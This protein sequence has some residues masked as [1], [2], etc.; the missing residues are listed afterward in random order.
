MAP[1]RIAFVAAEV[2]PFAK[3]GGLA[4]VAGALPAYL[5][6]EHDVRVFMPLHGKIDAAKYPTVAV[7]FLQ[8][9][10]IH[11]GTHFFRFSV[12]TAKLPGTEVDVYFIDCPALFD[13]PGIY[14][15]EWDEH[16]R[17]AL[18]SRAVL[19][20]CQH[21][22]WGPDI[23][24]CNDWHTALIPLYL[25]TLFSWDH[26]FARTRT[27]LTL[28]NVAYQGIFPAEV[29]GN[30]GFSEWRWLLYQDDLDRGIINF[31]KTGLL[32]AGAIT[33]VSI[34][35]A[36]EI[37]TDAFGM[38]M[39][40]VL[41]A[42]S[43]SVVGIV[44]GVDYSVWDPATDPYLK[45]PYTSA[46]VREGKQANR[47][48]LMREIGLGDDP[49]APLLAVVS[50]LTAQKGFDL[51]FEP[52]AEALRYLNLRFLVLGSGE[53][54]LEA[55]FFDLQRTF[56]HKCWFFRGY[57]ERL[58]HAIEA[59][60]DI[61]LMPSRFEP[62]GLNQMYSLKYGAVPVVR[63]T[64]GLADTVEL[65]DPQKGT[66]TGV[67]FDNYDVPGFTWGLRTAL[68]LFQNRALF[69]QVQRNGMAKDYSWDRQGAE[70]TR[71][72]RALLGQG[73]AS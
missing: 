54:G 72:Y 69:T 32:Y 57:H 67:V 70:Y 11:L 9:L 7:E 10:P 64:G 40:Q 27:V 2:A 28:H 50:R 38:G 14:T 35:Y 33:A 43:S 37:Q 23:V 24:H 5:A 71:L 30:L 18:F 21:M 34:T 20:S 62:C 25:R 36:K 4:D 29:I 41:R 45:H 8:H 19:M 73:D 66:G 44:N 15:G 16:L 6:G 1:L 31:L 26:L 22:G 46:N 47:Q 42:R 63:K 48:E 61:F 51:V 59:A 49:K 53:P 12:R 52:M 60:A 58:A 13:R 55:R 56:P 65:F 68:Q 17:F 3:T 39:Q